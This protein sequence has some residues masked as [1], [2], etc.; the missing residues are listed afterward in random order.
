MSKNF[1][2]SDFKDHLLADGFTGDLVI[3]TDPEYAASLTRF[4]KNAQKNAGLVA[5]V[6]S[7]QDV[8]K[9]IKLVNSHSFNSPGSINVVVRGGG[10]S[11]S[12]SSSTE[13]GIV[14]DL[15][16]H[17]STVR[18]DQEAKLGYVAGG[19]TW[20]VVDREAIKYQLALVGGTVSHTGVGG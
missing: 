8:S 7:S 17:M 5:F 14:I 3:P 6:K 19:A 4:A 18:I 2:S 9:V 16:R 15:S 12:G 20:S 10:H 1:H 11:T 13:G